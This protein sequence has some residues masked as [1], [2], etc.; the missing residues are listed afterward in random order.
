M[1]DFRNTRNPI[2]PLEHHVPDSE[3]H[4]FSDG[5]LYLYGSYDGI[6]ETYCSPEYRVI[7]TADMKN[8][9]VSDVSF[10]GHDVPW[11]YDPNA[12]KYPGLDFSNP[13]PFIK[14]MMSRPPKPG[15]KE[16]T[17]A[18]DAQG[19]PLPMLY[20]PDCIE[21]DGKFYLYFC[22]TDS[23]EGVAVS[24][25]P[26]GPFKNP[27]QLPCGGINPAIFIDDDGQAYYYWGQIWAKGV[28]LNPDMMSFD[29]ADTV[30]NLVTE[31]EHY[32]HEGSSM[33]KIGDT[34]Y[35]VYSDMQRGKP[36]ALGYATSKNPLGPFE[37]QGIIIDNDGCDPETWNDHGS[38]ECVNGQWY[39]FYHRSTRRSEYWRRLCVEKITV[40][41]DGKIPE[42]IPTSQG[43]GDPFA[44]GEKI[45]GYQACVM[46]GN[47]WIDADEKYG[48]KITAIK[49]GDTATFR[50]V[51]SA[52]DWKNIT[53]TA[54]GKGKI[55]VLMNGKEAGT[56][57][58]TSENTA[59]PISMPAGEYELT[60][61]FDESDS[62][63]LFDL[64]LE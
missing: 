42:V 44:P 19:R 4:V 11:F 64:T 47:C 32:F 7:S 2:L 57:A 55:T 38:I 26:M 17:P 60:L 45:M 13:S 10:S 28:K 30:E 15:K 48:E 37:Y 54:A 27:V 18:V 1:T 29:P 3:A 20:A 9:T 6:G 31:E 62:L 41:P 22:M 49:N 50:Y 23:S 5:K 58:V 16:A 63:E 43:L 53:V 61:R 56:I 40:T 36:T 39:V 8:W 12:P 21:K 46:S 59:A 52:A 24:D 51:R 25:S 35:M 34:Y 14:W 33:R